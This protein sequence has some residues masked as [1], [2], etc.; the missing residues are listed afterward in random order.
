MR[1]SQ[2]TVVLG[3]ILLL[4]TADAKQPSPRL[5]RPTREA[6]SEADINA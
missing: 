1:K 2:A 6:P 5:R 3:L 4:S